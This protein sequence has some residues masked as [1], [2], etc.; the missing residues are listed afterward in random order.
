M[1]PEKL[2]A[3]LDSEIYDALGYIETETTEARRKALQYYNREGYGNEVEGR[4][5]IVTGEVAEAIDG[6]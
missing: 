1:T 3:V 4:S 5:Q 2:R 6:A